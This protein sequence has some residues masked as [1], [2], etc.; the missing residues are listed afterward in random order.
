M[1]STREKV[2]V[3]VERKGKEGEE[4]KGMR[5]KEGKKGKKGKEGKEEKGMRKKERKKEKMI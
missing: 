5:T 1:K 4:R 3:E 2:T